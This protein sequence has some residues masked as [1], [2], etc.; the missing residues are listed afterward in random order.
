MSLMLV[1]FAHVPDE[2]GFDVAFRVQFGA[3]VEGF[4]DGVAEEFSGVEPFMFTEFGE[5]RGDYRN[6]WLAVQAWSSL[7][8]LCSRLGNV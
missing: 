3:A 4:F 5:S 2:H 6:K 7:Y 8:A 1:G